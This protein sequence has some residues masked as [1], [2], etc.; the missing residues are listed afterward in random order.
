[1]KTLTKLD[2]ASAILTSAVAAQADWQ[3]RLAKIR[4]RHYKF[5]ELVRRSMHRVIESWGKTEM[6]L[7]PH[8]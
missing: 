5:K 8:S 6:R 4:Y 3:T 7:T 1:M 2:L